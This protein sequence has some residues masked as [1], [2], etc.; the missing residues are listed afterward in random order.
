MQLFYETINTCIKVI[1]PL[2]LKYTWSQL[3]RINEYLPKC[4]EQLEIVKFYFS[5]TYYKN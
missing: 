5:N 3:D 1:D 2:V 4:Y